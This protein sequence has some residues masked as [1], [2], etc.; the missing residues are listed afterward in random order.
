MI[1]AAGEVIVLN[2]RHQQPF[3]IAT[4]AKWG[5]TERLLCA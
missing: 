3:S 2:F 5:N 1:I 4:E